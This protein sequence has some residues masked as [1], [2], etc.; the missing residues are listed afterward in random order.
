MR[1]AI[2]DDEEKERVTTEACLRTHIRACC[3]EEESA[4]RISELIF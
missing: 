4:L 3:P 2:V 1:I